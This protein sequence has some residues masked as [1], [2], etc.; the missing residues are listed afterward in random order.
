MNDCSRNTLELAKLRHW[1]PLLSFLHIQCHPEAEIAA[2]GYETIQLEAQ[3][4]Y[5]QQD[6]DRYRRLIDTYLERYRGAPHRAAKLEL[7]LLSDQKQLEQ[8]QT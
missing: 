8:L 2:S 4:V 6:A 3:N 7:L 1:A 5:L